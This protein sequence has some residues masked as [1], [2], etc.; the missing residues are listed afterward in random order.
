MAKYDFAI[1]VGGAPGQG[2]ET[3]G[4]SISQIFAR[5]GLN[6]FTYTAYQSLIRGGHSFL[7]IRISSEPIAN[8]GDKIDLIVALDR[9]S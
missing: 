5:Y 7:T 8:H 4:K 9:D 2:I 3:A 1:A 6:V